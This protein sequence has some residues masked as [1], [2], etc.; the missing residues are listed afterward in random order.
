MVPKKT[1]LWA[2]GLVAVAAAGL[3]DWR[4]VSAAAQ[5]S[6][7]SARTVAAT[8]AQS[9]APARE[10]WDDPAVLHVGIERPHATMMTYPSA[11]LAAVAIAPP[12]PGSVP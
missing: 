11:E 5:A 7:A 8:S 6:G 1:A 10:E 9:G 2:A 12:R 3:F 4:P